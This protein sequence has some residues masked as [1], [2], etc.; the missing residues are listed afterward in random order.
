ENEDRYE[1]WLTGGALGQGG[2]LYLDVPVQAIRDLIEQHGGEHPDQEGDDTASEA[3]GQ[4]ET[5]ESIVIQALAEWGIAAHRDD[6]AGNTWLAIGHDQTRAGFPHM[7]AEPYVVLYLYNDTDEEEIT[8]TRAPADGDVWDV[9]RGDGTGA[10]CT[11]LTRP[12]DQL[13]ACVEAIADWITTPQVTPD[14]AIRLAEL[15]ETE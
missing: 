7:L 6:D 10:E 11:L 1:D 8:V 2:G 13:T 3:T 15:N 9:V 5:A 4:D 12:A 14:P